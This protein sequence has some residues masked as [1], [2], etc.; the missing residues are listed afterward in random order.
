MPMRMR[1]EVGCTWCHTKY[2][3]DPEKG[4]AVNLAA[5]VEQPGAV[6]VAFRKHACLNPNAVMQKPLTIEDYM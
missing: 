1:E 4:H 3:W 5:L 2:S 6:A